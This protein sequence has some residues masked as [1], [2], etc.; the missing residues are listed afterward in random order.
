MRRFVSVGLWVALTIAWLAILSVSRAGAQLSSSSGSASGHSGKHEP[1]RVLVKAA[2]SQSPKST[3]Q[4]VTGKSGHKLPP[5]IIV[6]TPTGIPQPIG[7]VGTTTSVVTQR[8]VQVQ[9]THQLPDL[10]RQVPGV[11][12]TQLGSPGTI[13]DVSIRG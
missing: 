9:Q 10:L 2:K 13:T 4:A 6:L 3:G 11:E 7:E 12:V 5:I 8:Q 1:R